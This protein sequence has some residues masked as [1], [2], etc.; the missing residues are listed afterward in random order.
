MVLAKGTAQ[1]AA[2]YKNCA[3]AALSDKGRFLSPVNHSG[4]NAQFRGFPAE[5]SFSGKAVNTAAA[6]AHGTMFVK[7][8]HVL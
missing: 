7:I 8:P 4:A 1:I 6:W 5:T 2:A 3:R